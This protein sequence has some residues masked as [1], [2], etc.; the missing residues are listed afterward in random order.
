MSDFDDLDEAKS[1]FNEVV[2]RND[3][4]S[5]IDN[6]ESDVNEIIDLIKDYEVKEALEKLEELKEKLY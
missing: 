3:F 2:E 6:I 5:A 1:Y 4:I